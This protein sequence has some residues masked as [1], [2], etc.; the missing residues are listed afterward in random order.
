[1]KIGF[2]ELHKVNKLLKKYGKELEKIINKHGK[3]V[4]KFV[5]E[6]AIEILGTLKQKA[7]DLDSAI[8]DMGG[9]ENFFKLMCSIEE[10]M[11][12]FLT[13]DSIVSWCKENR[14]ASADK[15]AILLLDS[16]MFSGE[17]KMENCNHG[18]LACFLDKDDE[19]IESK[20]KYFYAT[21]ME[22]RLTETFGDQDMII[23]K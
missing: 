8:S 2:K 11:T 5:T 20:V 14:P 23:L 19:L 18:C 13:L 10:E 7:V 17:Y 1:M 16:S 22:K 3:E 6:E 4:V 9:I 15:A 21:Y 12:E